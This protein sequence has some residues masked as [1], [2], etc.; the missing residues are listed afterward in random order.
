MFNEI[1][2]IVGTPANGHSGM[3]N[4]KTSQDDWEIYTVHV[5]GTSMGSKKRGV[6]CYL[7]SFKA[8]EF[9]G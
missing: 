4:W 2:K 5:G 6:S 1:R 3:V 7:K 9:V 8:L